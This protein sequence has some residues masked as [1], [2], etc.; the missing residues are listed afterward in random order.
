M[1]SSSGVMPFWALSLAYWLHMLATLLWIG[2]LVVVVL[3]IQPIARHVLSSRDFIHLME[4][5]QQRLNPLAWT[6]LAVLLATGLFQMSASPKYQ[7]F[8]SIH[9]RWSVAI[10]VKHILFLIMVGLSGYITW[11]VMPAIRRNALLE[12]RE[13]EPFEVVRLRHREE[14]LFRLNLILG[15]LI[16]GLTALARAS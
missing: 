8:L 7:G 4:K 10:F 2:G 9:S 11:W 12:S 13:A 6:S 14:W 5:V 1:I 16:L 15:I 3:F